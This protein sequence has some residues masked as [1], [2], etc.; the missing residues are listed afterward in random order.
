MGGCA[1]IATIAMQL[2]VPMLVALGCAGV[3]LAQEGGESK[4][5]FDV[6][7]VKLL[8]TTRDVSRAVR[9]DPGG[10]SGN[11]TL[12]RLVA[13]A[14]SVPEVRVAGFTPWEDSVLFAV[15]ARSEKAASPQHVRLM[16]R[17][18][19]AERFRLRVHTEA[20][21]TSYHAIVE[22]R[23][24]ISPPPAKADD[25]RPFGMH[26]RV[27]HVPDLAMLARWMSGV[28]GQIVIDQTGLE[29][30]DITIPIASPDYENFKDD[31]HAAAL[32]MRDEFWA[33]FVRGLQKMGLR[34][35]AIRGPLEF[36]VIDSAERPK[37]N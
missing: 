4:A 6:A 11:A 35:E 26:E 20:R 32:A 23:Q 10:F 3:A 34:V 33:S 29:G 18:L 8:P 15:T 9:I 27:L 13:E 24:G 2:V 19:L 31:H 5:A 12:R 16:L 22:G 1:A 37:E 7:S 30:I 36:L 21:Q 17:T 14:Y 25:D 28:S